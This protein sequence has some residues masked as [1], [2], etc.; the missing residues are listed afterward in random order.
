[1]RFSVFFGFFATLIIFY[2]SMLVN[3][4]LFGSMPEK[5]KKV[6]LIRNRGFLTRTQRR[7]LAFC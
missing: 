4:I 6:L 3:L 5:K 2:P 1:M 7:S